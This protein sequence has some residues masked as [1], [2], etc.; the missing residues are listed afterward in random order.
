MT[1]TV[2]LPWP[3]PKLHPNARVHWAVRSKAA[4]RTRQT[5]FLLTRFAE[6]R[7]LRIFDGTTRVPVSLTFCPPDRRR[8]DR[9]GMLS[10]CKSALDG[11]AD[12]LMVNDNLFDLSI[13][14]RD[15]VK[16]GKV[17]VVVG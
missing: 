1:L 10:A 5:A 3:S 4:K 17:V 6:G 16:G 15:P 11:L 13:Q 14:V 7:N 8:R 12:A 2:E 9:D